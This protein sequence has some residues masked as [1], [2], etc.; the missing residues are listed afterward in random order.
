MTLKK[1]VSLLLLMTMVLSIASCAVDYNSFFTT[2]TTEE[3]DLG[4]DDLGNDEGNNGDNIDAVMDPTCVPIL[5]IKTKNR[6]QI[7]A[8]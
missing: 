6:A 1:I 2:T 4:G 8:K 5:Q 3:N 7:S